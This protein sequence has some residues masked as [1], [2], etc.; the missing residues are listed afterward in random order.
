MAAPTTKTLTPSATKPAT[1]LEMALQHR[2]GL[3][4]ELATLNASSARLKETAA[5]EAAVL[6][7]IDAM[8]AAEIAGMTEWATGGC[9]GDA[10]RPD[11]NKRIILG[12]KL[13]AAQ[14]AATAAK[15]ACADIG[16]KIAGLNERLCA[17]GA[18]IEEAI[19]DK[20][21]TEHGFIID[22]YRVICEN[23][24]KLAAQIHGLANFYGEKGRNLISHGDQD[25]GTKYLQSASALTSI[26]LP[27][28]GVTR[29]EIEA[30]A[31][32]WGRRAA[33]LR[34]GSSS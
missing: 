1:A 16:Q 3:A 34:N 25:A 26:R 11:Q 23:G 31:H 15:G 17:I 27:S 10:P 30:A 12:Q 9:I 29:H 21:E 18:Q 13:N 28:P 5:S 32:E 6:R 14:A 19:F 2:A 33:D 4:D 8:G 24:S 20:L 22:Q 7:E